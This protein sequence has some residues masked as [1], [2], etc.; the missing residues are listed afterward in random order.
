MEPETNNDSD[1]QV[2]Q[3]KIPI[4]THGSFFHKRNPL[5]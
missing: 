4:L 3:R 5:T 1:S 2:D